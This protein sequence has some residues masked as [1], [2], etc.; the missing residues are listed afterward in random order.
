MFYWVTKN[1]KFPANKWRFDKADLHCS[2]ALSKSNVFLLI[3][4]KLKTNFIG[5][6][7]L[8]Y[9]GCPLTRER[10]QKK[11]PI[12]IFKSESVRLRECV[13][14]EF[15]W[16]VKRGFEKASVRRPVRLRECPLAES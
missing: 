1:S 7:Q 15:D 6:S 8:L 13:N 16:E 4:C 14:T 5:L 10:K 12:F 9:M 11:N 2:V 3:C